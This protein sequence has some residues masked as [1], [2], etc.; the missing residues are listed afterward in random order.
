MIPTPFEVM[1]I[2]E[3][4]GFK[5]KELIIIEQYNCKATGYPFESLSDELFLSK[6]S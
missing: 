5:L 4:A 2:F 6:L 1:K 3:A